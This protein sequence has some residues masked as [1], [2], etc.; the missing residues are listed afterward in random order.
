MTTLTELV[1]R[2]IAMWNETDAARRRTLIAQ[3]W[4]ETASYRDPIMQGEGHA[5]IDAMV[6]GVQERFAGHQFHRRSEVDA[7]HDRIRFTWDLAP[8]D[9]PGVVRG[10]DFG[11]VADGRLQTIT[12]FVDHTPAAKPDV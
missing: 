7:H 11:V 1:D 5:G 9:G 2:Y 6:Q 3:T 10:T 4:T 8:A 12:G